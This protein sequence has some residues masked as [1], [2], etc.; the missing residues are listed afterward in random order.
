MSDS[1]VP[2][3][4]IFDIKSFAVHDGP[5]IRT[6]VFLKGC[7]LSCAWCHNPEAIS[8]RPEIAF[9]ES[10]CIA[11]GA[12]VEV[13]PEQAQA[14]SPEGERTFARDLCVRCG[15]CVEH[16]HAEALVMQ[17]RDMSV[18]EVMQE[19][20]QDAPFYRTSG[21]GV[22][23]SGGEPLLQ[24]RFVRAL[25]EQC[26]ERGY[27]TAVDTCGQ[28]KWEVMEGVL[29]FV[30]LFLYDL[31]HA[32]T[33]AHRKHTGALNEPILENL[34][35]LSRAGAA[36]EVRMPIVPT[37]NDDRGSIT[38]AAEILAELET[39]TCVRLLP[40]HALA[41]EKYR[42]VGRENEM[43]VVGETNGEKMVEIAG[44]IRAFGVE[45]GE[46]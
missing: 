39:L 16:C 32:D 7:S 27:H 35:R 42:S 37:V 28:V 36:I 30:D 24:F 40:Y 29:P 33:F 6:T 14:L 4:R 26:R 5:G 8:P 11:C 38:A 25:L 12:C 46:H 20:S 18:D 43:A 41:G 34:R 45:V 15:T 17:G 10:R 1:A 31:K 9:H 21:G 2:T 22:T 23:V 3:A 44:W 19:V 13:C